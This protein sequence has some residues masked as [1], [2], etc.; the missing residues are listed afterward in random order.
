MRDGDISKAMNLLHS[1]GIAGV[2]EAVLLQMAHKHPTRNPQPLGKGNRRSSCAMLLR[3]R[4]P[5]RANTK[6][7][8]SSRK[9]A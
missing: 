9:I 2:T 6:H 4:T 3:G 5:R 8:A 1:L 7:I